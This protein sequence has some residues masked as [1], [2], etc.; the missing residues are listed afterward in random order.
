D[1]CTPAGTRT[2]ATASRAL[3]SG[4]GTRWRPSGMR[5]RRRGTS[6]TSDPVDAGGVAREDLGDLVLREAPG[7]LRDVPLRLGPEGDAVGVVAR[8]HARVGEP[9]VAGT[10]H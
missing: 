7:E 8:E 3:T 10:H 4:S 1:A 9:G 5:W 2:P 6:G